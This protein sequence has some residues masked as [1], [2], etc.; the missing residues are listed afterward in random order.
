MN[1]SQSFVRNWAL[2]AL[3]AVCVVGCNSGDGTSELEAS[4]A[5][6]AERNFK[7]AN[8]LAN[9]AVKRSKGS[10]DAYV[11]SAR[12]KLALGYLDEGRK[13]TAAA[14]K[15][16]EH[17]SDALLLEAKIAYHQKDYATA[18]LDFRHIADDPSYLP[19]ERSDA[20]EGIGV[21]QMSV[22]E[23]EQA[24]V[25]LLRAIRLNRRNAAAWYHLGLL[26]R[27]GFGFQATAMEQ[28]QFYVHLADQNDSRV[29][30][31]R[32]SYIPDLKETLDRKAA[33]ARGVAERDSEKG[34]QLLQ[35]GDQ[36]LAKN[37][38]KNAKAKYAAALKADPLNYKAAIALAQVTPKVDKTPEGAKA[39]LKAYRVACALQPSNTQLLITTADLAFRLN[40]QATALELY[41]RAL[42]T[43]PVDLNALDGLVKCIKK[44]GGK[45]EVAAAYEA[46]R[47]ELAARRK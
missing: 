1:S 8:K 26:Y 32:D 27:D 21:V 25:A 9:K 7:D 16:D 31:V 34:A 3:A 29:Q 38:P 28:F 42:A 15:L 6:Y 40:F 23:F 11:Q 14:L 19:E 10:I 47:A 35:E 43:N 22:N 39:Q 17:A 18:M 20:L 37:Q 12:V 45:Q 36:L 24:R 2:A 4:R 46:Y 33:T 5:A 30:R 13:A 41:S 44:V